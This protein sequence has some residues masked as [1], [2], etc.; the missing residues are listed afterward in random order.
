MWDNTSKVTTFLWAWMKAVVN[1]TPQRENCKKLL[2]AVLDCC[3]CF[4][5]PI[6]VC[7]SCFSCLFELTTQQQLTYTVKDTFSKTGINNKTFNI[8]Q[9]LMVAAWA[10][11]QML[12]V[13]P[14]KLVIFVTYDSAAATLA[15]AFSSASSVANNFLDTCNNMQINVKYIHQV[16]WLTCHW[17]LRFLE[18]DNNK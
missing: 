2:T 12:Y 6:K 4:S 7:M 5:L 16:H 10:T 17:L 1:R 13:P 8:K 9:H 11:K 3:C 18:I 15:S 14:N